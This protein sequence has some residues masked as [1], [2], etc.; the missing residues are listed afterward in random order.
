[1]SSSLCNCHHPP[2][3][4]FL[5]GLNIL[6]SILFTITQNT[7]FH[8]LVFVI[9][10]TAGFQSTSTGEVS[11]KASSIRHNT[12]YFPV[13]P[14]IPPTSHF[15]LIH[16]T[17]IHCPPGS[18]QRVLVSSSFDFSDPF[19]PLRHIKRSVTSLFLLLFFCS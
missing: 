10:K 8:F 5:L 7:K 18:L 2:K 4:Y 1:M 6:P 17:A 3:T 19:C 16:F 11:G 9:S 13:T 14:S 15:M 12:D